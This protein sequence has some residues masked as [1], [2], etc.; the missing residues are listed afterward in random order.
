MWGPLLDTGA[1]KN[2]GQKINFPGK[3]P[4]FFPGILPGIREIKTIVN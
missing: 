3:I 4:D 2:G 1:K